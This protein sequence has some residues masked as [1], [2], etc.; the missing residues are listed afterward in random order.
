MGQVNSVNTF[1][2]NQ[3]LVQ[4][5]GQASAVSGTAFDE[6]YQSK[7]EQTTLDDIFHQVATE[8]G[9][10]ESLLKAVAQ[11]ESGFDTNAVSS[12]GAMGI[13]QL[14]PA[15]AE[16]LGVTD[17]F[18]AKQCIE[19]GAKMLSY[20]LDDYNGNVTLALAAYNAGSGSVQKYGGVPPYNETLGY[21]E[22]INNILGGALANDSTKVV[23]AQPT[24]LG[25][26]ASDT[27]PDV[28]IKGS[29][30]QNGAPSNGVTSN[31]NTNNVM[32]YNE[33]LYFLNTYKNTFESL[34]EKMKP[35][36]EQKMKTSGTQ[37]IKQQVDDSKNVQLHEEVDNNTKLDSDVRT[38]DLKYNAS[39]ANVAMLQSSNIS[40]S[41]DNLMKNSAQSLYE[42]QASM[43]SPL[44]ARLLDL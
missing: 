12:C 33:Y 1:D 9:V 42:A 22:K 44:V 16:S 21:I 25:G 27:A 3:Y 35:E 34:M 17:P 10:N 15:T 7:T 2:G 11:A 38:Q 39:I 24:N 29:G 26:V 30:A 20:L 37:V 41:I 13:M 43:V 28:A 5:D 18:D 31:N 40:T 14:M 23:D 32:N 8:Y 6:I 4:N 19:G 36:D